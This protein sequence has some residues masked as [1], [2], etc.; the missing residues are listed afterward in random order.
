M[1][2]RII[3]LVDAAAGRRFPDGWLIRGSRARAA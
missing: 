1:A 3:G 2:D